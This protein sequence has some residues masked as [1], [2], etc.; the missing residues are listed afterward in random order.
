MTMQRE[1]SPYETATFLSQLT[2]WWLNGRIWQGWRRS[3]RH[4]ELPNLNQTEKCRNVAPVLQRNWDGELR[5][6]G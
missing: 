5:R 2:W 1:P 3:L 4:E 6:V